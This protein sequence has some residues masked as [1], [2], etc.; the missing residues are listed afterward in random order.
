MGRMLS[1]RLP[2][3][4]QRGEDSGRKE[5]GS[6]LSHIQSTLRAWAVAQLGMCLSLHRKLP[7]CEIQHCIKRPRCIPIIPTLMDYVG[8]GDS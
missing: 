6:V 1:H 3:Q 7:G 8:T 4:P 5:H 2:R